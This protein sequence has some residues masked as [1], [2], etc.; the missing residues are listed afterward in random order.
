TWFVPLA[1]V[2]EPAGVAHAVAE[3][4]GAPTGPGTAEDRVLRR[5]RERRA[6]IVLD[7]C[8]HLAA[9]AAALTDRLLAACPDLRL[10]ATS[11]EPL[12]LAGEAQFPLAPLPTPAPDTVRVELTG[13]DA[14]RLFVERARDADPTFILDD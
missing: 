11:R 7:N 14:V 10:L 9:A 6:L 8:E 12:S 13:S 3:A 5:L 2:A 1:G 4:I